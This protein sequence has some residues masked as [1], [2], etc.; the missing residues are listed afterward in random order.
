MRNL[1]KLWSRQPKETISWYKTRTSA[2]SHRQ[3]VRA[4]VVETN[5][6]IE[7]ENGHARRTTG[8]FIESILSLHALGP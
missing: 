1:S 2:L 5:P 7:D 3:F 8:R 6:L 4:L